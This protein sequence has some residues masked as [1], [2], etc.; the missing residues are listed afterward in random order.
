MVKEPYMDDNKAVKVLRLM[1]Q[2]KWFGS[3]K[4][5]VEIDYPNHIRPWEKQYLPESRLVKV[6]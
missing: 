3:I 2:E 6:K 5:C 1:P 4:D